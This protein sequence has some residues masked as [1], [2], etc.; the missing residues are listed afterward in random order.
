MN[1]HTKPLAVETPLSSGLEPVSR[2]YAFSFP[3][4]PRDRVVPES[5]ANQSSGQPE[6]SLGADTDNEMLTVQSRCTVCVGRQDL[7]G[8]TKELYRLVARLAGFASGSDQ[9]PLTKEDASDAVRCIDRY[10][11]DAA[12][13]FNA[14]SRDLSTMAGDAEIYRF[15]ATIGDYAQVLCDALHKGDD[16]PDYLKQPWTDILGDL[17]DEESELTDWKASS[18]D[19]PRPQT[20]FMDALEQ[21]VETLVANGMT[22]L[23]Y[24]LA[25]FAARTYGRRNSL[26]HGKSFNKFLSK[27]FAGYAECLDRD[28]QNLERLLPDKE[29]HLAGKYRRIIDFARDYRIGKDNDGNWRKRQ[30][31]PQEEVPHQF[32]PLSKPA[33]RSSLEMGRF[34]PTGLD[35]PPPLCVSFSPAALRRH[36]VAEQR[37]TKRPAKEQPLGQPRVK[38]VCGLDY[39]KEKV[40]AVTNHLTDTDHSSFGRLIERLHILADQLTRLSPAKASSLFADQVPQLELELERAKGKYDKQ[41]KKVLKKKKAKSKYITHLVDNHA[42]IS[43]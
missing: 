12:S 17:G 26:F 25:L 40:E 35:G 39:G 34:R 32:A 29:K 36:T 2:D 8:S 4:P 38:A 13:E 22:D 10:V 31:P 7:P 9:N 30:V 41:S 15:N 43:F 19:R 21:R 5:P 37:G 27:D 20:P 3:V 42:N 14:V 16:V 24:D 23:D 6:S 33:L 18:E 28:D 1:N 11:M